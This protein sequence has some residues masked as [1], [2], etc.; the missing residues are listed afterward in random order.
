[1]RRWGVVVV[2]LLA[3]AGC[4]T[5]R[6]G[7]SPATSPSTSTSGR[8]GPVDLSVPLDLARVTPAGTTAPSTSVLPDPEGTQ[9][10]LE[11][12]FLTITRL[13]QA[14]VQFQEYAGTWG[15][16]LT[17]T[18]ADA[19]VFGDWTTDHVGEQVAVVAGGSVI[20]APQIQSPITGGEVVISAR[21]TQ[22][23]ANDLLDR[24]TGR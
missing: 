3:L 14:K 2:L 10:T 1:M 11:A 4:S 24:L 21:Y 13:E 23:E 15:V 5:E 6:V 16:V 12:P 19:A 7:G 20:F 17:M 9:L 22:D 8:A 18:D